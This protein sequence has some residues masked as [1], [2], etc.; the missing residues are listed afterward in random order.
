M[1]SSA[2]A[3]NCIFDCDTVSIVCEQSQ[4]NHSISRQEFNPAAALILWSPN[5]F[6]A[7][8]TDQFAGQQ[9]EQS[10][11]NGT[12]PCAGGGKI[13]QKGNTSPNTPWD[14]AT[15]E[16]VCDHCTPSE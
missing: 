4:G 10:F 7:T 1:T 6:D 15:Y 13:M 9:R 12:C 14:D 11:P 8:P 16:Q 3:V 5:A 2:V